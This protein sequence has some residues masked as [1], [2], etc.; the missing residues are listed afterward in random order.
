MGI[1]TNVYRV[2]L[3]LKRP[4]QFPRKEG[5]RGV[6]TNKGDNDTVE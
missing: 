5:V 4:Q 6:K 2:G 3:G 1:E